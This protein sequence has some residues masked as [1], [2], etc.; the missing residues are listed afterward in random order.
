MTDCS[1]KT[2]PMRPEDDVIGLQFRGSGNTPHNTGLL[3]LHGAL[4]L[5][6]L[7]ALSR[8][9]EPSILRADI[10]EFQLLSV[11]G[12]L[13]HGNGYPIYLTLANLWTRV[14]LGEIPWRVGL[15]SALAAAA[16]TSLLSLWTTRLTGS[17][18]VGLIAG[19]VFAMSNAVWLFGTVALPYALDTFL[20][21]AIL[22]CLQEWEATERDRWLATALFLWSLDYGVHPGAVPTRT[23]HRPSSRSDPPESPWWRFHG[24]TTAGLRRESIMERM[25]AVSRKKS[26]DVR[27][28]IGAYIA[29]ASIPACRPNSRRS[30]RCCALPADLVPSGFEERAARRSCLSIGGKV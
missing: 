25:V 8:A 30:R 12:G 29:P 10:A 4:G 2:E 9:V 23:G 11:T 1:A 27:A 28:R 21:L 19:A 13:A 24:P 26:D 14:P 5:V 17:C 22:L 20:I 16:T 3:W 15:F 7:L 6:T 18:A